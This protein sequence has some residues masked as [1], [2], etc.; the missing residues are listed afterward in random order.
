MDGLR[1]ESFPFAISGCNKFPVYVCAEVTKPMVGSP[2]Y[3]HWTCDVDQVIHGLG[4]WYRSHICEMLWDRL[5]TSNACNS[6]RRRALRT[7]PRMKF[8]L[9]MIIIFF[10]VGKAQTN[11]LFDLNGDM[12]KKGRSLSD[13]T[14]RSIIPKRWTCCH[15]WSLWSKYH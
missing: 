5:R 13:I 11:L 2:I 1:I 4:W 8:P 3:I 7:K 15:I 9:G 10:Q 14:S 12:G 6:E